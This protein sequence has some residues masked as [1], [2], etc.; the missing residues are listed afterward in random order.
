MKNPIEKKRNS[1]NARNLLY[2]SIPKKPAVI[3]STNEIIIH[4]YA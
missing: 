3:E 2:N 1:R 4:Y